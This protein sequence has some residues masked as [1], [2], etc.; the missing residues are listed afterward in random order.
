MSHHV[1]PDFALIIAALPPTDPERRAAWAHAMDCAPCLHALV[2][3]EK[4]LRLIDTQAPQAPE[5]TIDPALKQRILSSVA[6]LPPE[7]PAAPWHALLLALGAA[8]SAALAWLDGTRDAGLQAR[9]GFHC[10]FWELVFALG[11]LV[12]GAVLALGTGKQRSPRVFALIGIAGGLFGQV[13]LRTRCPVHDVNPHLLVF[14]TAG[15]LLAAGLG[16]AFARS[17]RWAD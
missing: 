13:L 17:M 5:Q 10:I 7:R 15:V 1:P 14:H 4:L 9:L 6:N 16:Y 2:Q 12:C 8:C 11:P 3:G